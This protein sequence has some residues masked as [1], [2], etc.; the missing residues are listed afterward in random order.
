MPGHPSGTLPRGATSRP[1]APRG[2]PG[3]PLC[4]SWLLEPLQ[5]HA[6]AQNR[7]MAPGGLTGHARLGLPDHRSLRHLQGDLPL[8]NRVGGAEDGP[9]APDQ[10]ARILLPSSTG[11]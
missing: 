6:R 2:E 1:H 10:T 3:N 4:H 7:A 11:G 5:G 9:W 8:Q